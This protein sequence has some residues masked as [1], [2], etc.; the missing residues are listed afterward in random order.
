MPSANWAPKTAPT[1]A[2]FARKIGPNAAV[3]WTYMRPWTTT[4]MSMPTASHTLPCSNAASSFVGLIRST[5]QWGSLF[6]ST[7]HINSRNSERYS[8]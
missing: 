2:R 1:A 5:N 6:A 8:S 3:A 7:R 4:T